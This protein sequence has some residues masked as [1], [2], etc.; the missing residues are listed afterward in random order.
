M[1]GPF[2]LGVNIGVELVPSQVADLIRLVIA[3]GADVEVG[4]LDDD[5]VG[6]G[7]EPVELALS[8]KGTPTALS[9]ITESF[10]DL[11]EAVPA[12][13]A[14]VR[15]EAEAE[16]AAGAE[17]EEHPGGEPETDAQPGPGD[18]EDTGPG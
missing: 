17:P 6:T 12:I 18:D 2:V 14:A 3:D 9:R 16:A 5:I 10:G 4:A 13:V 15:A 7:D 8:L 1:K 11:A